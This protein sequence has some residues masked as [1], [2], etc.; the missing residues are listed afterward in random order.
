MTFC[1][2][3]KQPLPLFKTLESYI[4]WF[5]AHLCAADNIKELWTHDIFWWH[6]IQTWSV[7]DKDARMKE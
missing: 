7:A 1:V 2:S 4:G 5:H 6:N 3:E